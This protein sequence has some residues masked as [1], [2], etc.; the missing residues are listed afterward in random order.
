MPADCVNMATETNLADTWQL[1]A[2][3][4]IVEGT[5]SDLVFSHD[6]GRQ[7]IIEVVNTHP[8]EP[9]T[10]TAYRRSGIPVVVVPCRMGDGEPSLGWYTHPGFA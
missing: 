3:T 7:Y 2:E 10:E 5:R 9:E 6:D 4:S 1:K 8:M